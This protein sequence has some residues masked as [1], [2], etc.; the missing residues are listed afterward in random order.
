VAKAKKE[1]ST[2]ALPKIDAMREFA[3]AVGLKLPRGKDKH[4]EVLGAV[5]AH[6]GTL[7]AEVAEDDHLECEDC[8]ERSTDATEF[9]PFCGSRGDVITTDG[10]EHVAEVVQDE[11]EP[12]PEQDAPL[13]ND[14]AAVLDALIEK[15]CE[16][17]RGVVGYS[18]EMGVIVK[19]IHDKQL[20]KSKGHKT[21]KAF[22]ESDEVPFARTTMYSL[23]SIA[24]RFSRK[25]YDEVGYQKLRSLAT[26]SDAEEREE[27]TKK[28]RGGATARE[29]T[30]EVREKR[31]AKLGKKP[32]AAASVPE[33]KKDGEIT[34]LAKVDGK[35]KTHKFVGGKTGRE[36]KN[37]GS[38]N[39]VVDNCY[40]RIPISK[41]VVLDIALKIDGKGKHKTLGGLVASFVRAK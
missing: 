10:E 13:A 18:Y 33:K 25:D 21:F 37:A 31:D 30:A 5:R 3:K 19:R 26:V 1:T 7:L 36:L 34:L 40:V 23:M 35:P 24:D 4:D 29:V 11:P 41:E 28:A 32:K 22:C 9:C 17:K 8:G 12:E 6:V 20:Y 2:K 39:I 16:M 38:F 27:L 14:G 15:L